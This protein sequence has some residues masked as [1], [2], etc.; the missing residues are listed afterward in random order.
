M[1]KNLGKL[2][3]EA[4]DFIDEVPNLR[5]DFKALDDRTEQM[6]KLYFEKDTTVFPAFESFKAPKKSVMEQTH[7]ATL[8]NA[9]VD[10]IRLFASSYLPKLYPSEEK[11]KTKAIMVVLHFAVKKCIKA[12]QNCDKEPEAHDPSTDLIYNYPDGVKLAGKT[13]ELILPWAITGFDHDY[14]LSSAILGPGDLTMKKLAILDTIISLYPESADSKDIFGFRAIHYA[15]RI[16][17][18]EVWNRIIAMR[19]EAIFELSDHG[20]TPLHVAAA[21][22]GSEEGTYIR[23]LHAHNVCAFIYFLHS[24]DL[25]LYS[26]DHVYVSCVPSLILAYS[27]IIYG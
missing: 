10:S 12:V 24:S 16:N 20:E 13:W 22:T 1:L 15:A 8:M 25:Q 5:D 2:R 6:F 23:T 3:E 9:V 7:I 27:Q 21:F 18:V 4:K 19:P 17:S 26:V 11:E 14:M